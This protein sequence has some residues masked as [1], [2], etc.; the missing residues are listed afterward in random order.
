[1]RNGKGISQHT[2]ARLLAPYEIRPREMWI[3]QT[4]LQG[5]LLENFRDAFERYLP[6]E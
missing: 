4:N 1:M 2:L 5:Y 6:H 3:V